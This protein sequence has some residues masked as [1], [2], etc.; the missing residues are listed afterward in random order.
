MFYTNESAVDQNLNVNQN[1]GVF[2]L[3]FTTDA[4]KI[5]HWMERHI[6]EWGT[7]IKNVIHR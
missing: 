6:R 4:I 7:T 3:K 2:I 5:V 1:I